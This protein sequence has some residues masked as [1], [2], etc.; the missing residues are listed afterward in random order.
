M[1]IQVIKDPKTDF[2]TFEGTT[3][4]DPL[5]SPHSCYDTVNSQCYFNESLQD[6]IQKCKDSPECGAGYYISSPR[7]SICAPLK[8]SL[9]PDSNPIYKLILGEDPKLQYNSFINPTKFEFPPDDAG[10]VYYGD[11]LQLKC[12]DNNT[13]LSTVDRNQAIDFEEGSI[14]RISFLN[15]NIFFNVPFLDRINYGDPLIIVQDK[16]S[17]IIQPDDEGTNALKWLLRLSTTFEDNQAFYFVSADGK[18][19]GD[20]VIYGDKFYIYRSAKMSGVVLDPFNKMIT[21]GPGPEEGKFKGYLTTFSLKRSNPLYTCLRGVCTSIDTTQVKYDGPKARY[22]DQIVYR[23]DNCF[24]QCPTS[25][26]FEASVLPS[27]RNVPKSTHPLRA[28]IVI[29]IAILVIL[30]GIYKLRD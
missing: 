27:P 13:F 16:S 17:L 3:F 6:C 15:P 14:S 7:E 5:K 25:S 20:P 9:F 10:A 28:K 4:N 21:Y 23:S 1:S 8:T 12:D 22:N 26:V 29:G 18:Q 19:I 30:I 24:L 2:Y 11:V